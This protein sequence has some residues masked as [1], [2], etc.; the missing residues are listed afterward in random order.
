LIDRGGDA[1][2]DPAEIGRLA[3]AIRPGYR[4]LVLVAAYGGLRIG[5]LAAHLAAQPS[6]MR[7]C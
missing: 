3:D 6:R 7:W 1:V 4:A 2:S 5:E